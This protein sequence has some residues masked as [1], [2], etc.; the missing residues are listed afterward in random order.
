MADEL[1]K[2]YNINR[3]NKEKKSSLL[4]QIETY[5]FN[6]VEATI[7][8]FKKELN[9]QNIICAKL[10]DNTQSII[11]NCSQFVNKNQSVIKNQLQ[12]LK[13]LDESLR[14]I[15]TQN[16]EKEELN[17]ELNELVNSEKST[18]LANDMKE[19]RDVTEN[20]MDFLESQNIQVFHN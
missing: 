16:N 4:S 17:E 9:K 14:E 10:G 13:D 18:Q 5:N 2:K 15:I 19:M 12:E 3:K 20:I 6:K 8:K 7:N 1:M 11:D